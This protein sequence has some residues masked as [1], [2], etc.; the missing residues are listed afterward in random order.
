MTVDYSSHY[1]CSMR[2]TVNASM[3]SGPYREEHLNGRDY[4][5]VPMTLIVPGV[6]DGS[7]GPLLYE[8]NELAKDPDLW[9][10]IPLIAYHP[11]V[12]DDEGQV[13]A[14]S[15][16]D[17]AV[18]EKS[19][20]GYNYR[21]EYRD[22]ALRSEGWF[23]KELVANYDANLPEEHR[24]LPRL[25]NG[26]PIEISTGLF[27]ENV[28]AKGTHNGTPYHYI[29][30]NYKSDH[31][32]ILP[33]QQGAC[34]VKDGCGTGIT[35]NTD[36]SVYNCR[37][38]YRGLCINCGGKG[39]KPGPCPKGEKKG[40]DSKV[41]SGG[42]KGSSS[43]SSSK[44]KSTTPAKPARKA[45]FR[46]PAEANKASDAA[47][48]AATAANIREP[49]KTSREG[50]VGVVPHEEALASYKKK[51]EAAAEAHETAAKEHKK[52]ADIRGPTSS[53]HASIADHH[54][55]MASHY[56]KRATT[57]RNKR[58][59]L[60][61]K[62]LPMK[63]KLI[64]WLTVNCDCWKGKEKILEQFEEEEIKDLK[65]Q[66]IAK[67]VTN[68]AA[69][70]FKGAFTTNAEG[71]GEVAGFDYATLAEF[72]SIEVDITKDPV[73]F[74]KA[75]RG[76]LQEVMDA[77]DHSEPAPEPKG[78]EPVT[79]ADP[80]SVT[81]NALDDVGPAQDPT[82]TSNKRRKMTA[83]EFKAMMPD[84][85]K[86]AW[87]DFVS[88]SRNER[89]ALLN[90][91]TN[92]ASPAEKKTLLEAYKNM[93]IPQLRVIAKR[94]GMPAQN[95]NRRGYLPEDNLPTFDVGGGYNPNT[96]TEPDDS[97]VLEVPVQNFSRKERFSRQSPNAL[98]SFV[99]D[100]GGMG[101]P[102]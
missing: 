97:D 89:V 63:E 39:G 59:N 5:V 91:I 31:I 43:K 4:V 76:K 102:E 12:T 33:D 40:S 17:P 7:N 11:E 73:G 60:N 87:N 74:I 96:A 47:H 3:D 85:F 28:P 95:N 18:L 77:L 79:M 48:K 86:D 70:Q 55:D 54:K 64:R 69:A 62:G 21:T 35:E 99:D 93:P 81:D 38:N 57:T 42:S 53:R 45:A 26:K 22:N 80:D 52:L 78:A 10:G 65:S 101:D 32:A 37:Y 27:A 100:D 50:G 6:L 56:R 1:S 9:N 71:E 29:A 58:S 67:R 19:K 23:D 16:R 72:F 68:A 25:L 51:Q 46:N 75:L 98:T 61:H 13:Q 94:M 14:V 15:A 49:I 83:Q 66:F 20:L 34:S 84:E 24:M 88:N 8:E 82:R 92:G 36:V 90:H 30:R 44:S 2:R 41:G